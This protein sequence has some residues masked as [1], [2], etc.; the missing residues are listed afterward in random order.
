M[1]S[2]TAVFRSTPPTDIQIER[3]VVALRDLGVVVLREGEERKD[4][5]VRWTSEEMVD[6]SH[7]WRSLMDSEDGPVTG[8]RIVQV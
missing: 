2:I 6:T 4:D 3:V 1:W 7:M 8:Y 5:W